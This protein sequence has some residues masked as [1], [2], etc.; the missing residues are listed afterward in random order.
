[1]FSYRLL[2]SPPKVVFLF[3]LLQGSEKRRASI[4]IVGNN[5]EDFERTFSLVRK[6]HHVLGCNAS[7]SCCD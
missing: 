1:M 6:S 4:A 2:G 5:E 7:G 3:E